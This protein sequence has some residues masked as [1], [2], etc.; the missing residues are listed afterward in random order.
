MPWTT[1]G[2]A[3]AAL[4]GGVL[5][6]AQGPIYARLA[7]GLDHNLLAAAFLAFLTATVFLGLIVLVSGVSLPQPSGLARMPAWVWLGG[8]F[9]AYQVMVSMTAVPR[10]GV[11][12]FIM[13]VVLGNMLGSAVYD[14]FGWFGLERR[15]LSIGAILGICIAFLGVLLKVRS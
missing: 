1:A 15:P 11:V 4:V 10:L 14:Q 3:A 5:V 13:I 9:G 8:L 7:D 12:S 2:L 6:A